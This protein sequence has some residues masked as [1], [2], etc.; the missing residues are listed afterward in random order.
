M[1]VEP[2]YEWPRPPVGGY[3]AEDLGRLPNLPPHT[4]LVDGSLVS[5]SPQAEFHM[6]ALRVLDNALRDAAPAEFEV[7]RE[8]TV[9]LGP[10]DRP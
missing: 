9:T 4:E 8:M 1:S 6:R 10:R 2:E 5:V 7:V 3:T